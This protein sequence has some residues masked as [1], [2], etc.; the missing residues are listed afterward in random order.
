MKMRTSKVSIH[1]P[2]LT[3]WVPFNWTMIFCRVCPQ[4]IQ[5]KYFQSIKE[6]QYNAVEGNH[7]DLTNNARVLFSGLWWF[8]LELLT[9]KKR[10]QYM[11][12]RSHVT[13][14]AHQCKIQH[15]VAG[16]YWLH[17]HANLISFLSLHQLEPL[18]KCFCISKL[19][20][21]LAVRS[22]LARYTLKH[23][24]TNARASFDFIS[25]GMIPLISHNNLVW[26]QHKQK[27]SL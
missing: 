20:Y 9:Y 11:Q 2:L 13:L 6:T 17:K 10:R 16:H 27:G 21:I 4:I 14:Q 25:R 12:S 22:D 1:I 26:P 24:Q 18:I 23:M 8:T 3:I 7:T 5:V 19:L 15:S